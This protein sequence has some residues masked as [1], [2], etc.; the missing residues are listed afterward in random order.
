MN[1]TVFSFSQKYLQCAILKCAAFNVWGF[2]TNVESM[3]IFW[4]TVQIT[5]AQFFQKFWTHLK[6]PGI[7]NNKY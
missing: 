2:T 4:N 7:R 6:T 3:P 1:Q 5:D